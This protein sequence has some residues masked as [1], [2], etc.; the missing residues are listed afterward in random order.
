MYYEFKKKPVQPIYIQKS[1]DLSEDQINLIRQIGDDLSATSVKLYG[2]WSK[3]EVDAEGSHFKLTDETR[4]IYEHLA[5]RC[6]WINDYSY[7]FDLDGFTENFY[8]LKYDHEG[9]HF[10]YHFDSGPSTPFPR[11]LSFVVQLSDPNEYQGG[12]FQIMGGNQK[13]ITAAKMKGTIIAFPSHYLHQVTPL[14][15]GTRRSL[16][17]FSGGHHFR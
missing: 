12:E 17:L 2:E 4:P 13:P 9:S 16:V 6:K 3:E 14:T 11:K 10:G 7:Q 5:N 8:Y 1:S 15:S